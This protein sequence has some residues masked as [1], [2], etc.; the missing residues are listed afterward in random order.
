MSDSIYP[1][2]LD[3]WDNL[4]TWGRDNGIW[5]AQLT[6]NGNSDDDGPDVWITPP[7]YVIERVDDLAKAISAATGVGQP[8]VE[9]AMCA[10]LE[11]SRQ[12]G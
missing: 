5:Y 6:R 8:T 9:A 10:G 12:H 2:F 11:F 3:G 7:R 1:L 4:S